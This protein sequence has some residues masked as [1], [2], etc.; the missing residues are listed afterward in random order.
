MAYVVTAPLVIPKDQ[1]GKRFHAY[2]G[3]VLPFLHDE[4][5]RHY[6]RHSLIEEIKHGTKPEVAPLDALVE[7]PKKTAPVEEWVK[8]GV[9]KGN[10]EAEL[11][12]LSK[13]ELIDL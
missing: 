8:F 12:G 11:R 3:T 9:S 2:R 4:E 7:K 13:D 6:L 5:R 10:D 1:M